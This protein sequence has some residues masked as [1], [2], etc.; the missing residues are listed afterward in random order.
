[1]KKTLIYRIGSIKNTDAKLYTQKELLWTNNDFDMLGITITNNPNCAVINYAKVIEKIKTICENWI[2]RPLTLM[3]KVLVVNALMESL[4]VYK[5]NAL[6]L[7]SEE[8]Y[9]EVEEIIYK[10]LWGE[11]IA[12]ISMKILQLSKKQGGL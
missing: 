6:E 3:G 12:N 8:M 4:F 5:L 2:N 1:M 7:M 9:K 11:K 10:F